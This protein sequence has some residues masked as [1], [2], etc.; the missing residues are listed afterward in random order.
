MPNNSGG[1]WYHVLSE[2]RPCGMSPVT[3]AKLL[4]CSRVV[5][6]LHSV[7]A[8]LRAAACSERRGSS[9][10]RGSL[11][12]RQ[13]TKTSFYESYWDMTLLKSCG[14]GLLPWRVECWKPLHRAGRKR[15]PRSPHGG[16]SK[17][18]GGKS[19]HCLYTHTPESI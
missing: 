18:T 10:A 2:S 13:H 3:S 12:L 15:I 1:V 7:W 5:L 6:L 19:C 8:S 4:T 17:W 9:V 16:F 11:V 14:P